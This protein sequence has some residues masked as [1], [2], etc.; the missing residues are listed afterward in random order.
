MSLKLTG[1]DGSYAF[2]AGGEPL[3]VT[4]ASA[5][6]PAWASAARGVFGADECHQGGSKLVCRP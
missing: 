4:I 6:P 2:G 1:R 5:D 3:T